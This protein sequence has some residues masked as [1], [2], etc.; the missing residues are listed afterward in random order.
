MIKFIIYYQFKFK[1]SD[2]LTLY[3]NK[4]YESEAYLFNSPHI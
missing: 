2:D 3:Q 4:C 1:I